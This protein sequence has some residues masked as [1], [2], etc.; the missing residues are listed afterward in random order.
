MSENQN[1]LTMKHIRAKPRRTEAQKRHF[2]RYMAQFGANFHPESAHG[3]KNPRDGIANPWDGSTIP[4][5][6]SAKPWDESVETSRPAAFPSLK[7]GATRTSALTVCHIAHKVREGV[8]A[9]GEPYAQGRHEL[10]HSTGGH[11]NPRYGHAQGKEPRRGVYA[12]SRHGNNDLFEADLPHHLPTSGSA[13]LHPRLLIARP[14]RGRQPLRST[15]PP[16]G[17][18]AT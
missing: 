1:H 13:A 17:K 14:L 10:R 16:Q 5:D 3:T 12:A 2:R 6:R 7:S 18:S 11:R 15:L 4:W 8:E 9:R